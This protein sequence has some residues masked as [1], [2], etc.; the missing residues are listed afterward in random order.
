MFYGCASVERI[1]VRFTTWGIGDESFTEKWLYNVS[2][3]GTFYRP[4]ALPKEFGE[5]RIPSGWTVV[6]ID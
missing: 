4:I 1:K 5:D 6:N 3:T 2:P